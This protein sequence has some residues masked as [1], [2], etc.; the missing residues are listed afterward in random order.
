[1]AFLRKLLFLILALTVFVIALLAAADNS[2]EVALK[3]LDYQ[4]P[5]WPVSWWMLAA[6]VF[7]VLFGSILNFVAN[8]RLRMDVRAANKSAASRSKELDQTKAEK[9]V[10]ATPDTTASTEP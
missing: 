9:M 4:T 1:M 3:F 10:E 2:N 8:T 5:V 7:G 6:F